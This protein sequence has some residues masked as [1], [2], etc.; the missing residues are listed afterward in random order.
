VKSSYAIHEAKA[1]FSELV[2]AARGGRELTI[3]DRGR[4]VARLVGIS[5]ATRL[6][7]RLLDLQAQGVLTAY[8]A[9]TAVDLE[10]VA[11]RR[12]ALGRFLATR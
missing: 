10:P 5:E 9:T 2:R 1:R 8:P 7:D 6:A 4:P 12:G 11:R 3:T